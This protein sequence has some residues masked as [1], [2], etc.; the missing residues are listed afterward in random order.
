MNKVYHRAAKMDKKGRVSAL[1]FPVPQ[2]INLKKELWTL[3]D[4][5]VTCEKC[6]I[7]MALAKANVDAMK[8]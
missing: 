1:C 7:M 2:A 5:A 4:E 6:K 3:R 8:P